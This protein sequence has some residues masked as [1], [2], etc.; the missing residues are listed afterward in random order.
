MNTEMTMNIEVLK[1]STAGSLSGKVS[2]PEVVRALI[3]EG[4]ESYDADLVRL[5]K[6]FYTPAGETH[7]EKLD[8]P[9]RPIGEEFNAAEVLS[10]IRASQTQAQPYP[11]FLRR[12]MDAGTTRYIVFLKGQKAIYFGR[13]GE[14]HVEEF[15]RA[16]K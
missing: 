7:V 3:A 13:K 2:F 6:T 4:V 10:A 15:P 1:L 9:P 14:F 8:F 5:Q 12:V 11:E 16:Q